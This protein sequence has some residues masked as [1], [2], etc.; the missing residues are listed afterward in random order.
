MNKTKPDSL[1]M[2]NDHWYNTIGRAF[3]DVAWRQLWSKMPLRKCWA[4]YNMGQSM[5]Q[6]K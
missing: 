5:R 3:D 2:E 6:M 4:I 1:I